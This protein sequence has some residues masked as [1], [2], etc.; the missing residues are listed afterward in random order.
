MNEMSFDIVTGA[1]SRSA[2]QPRLTQEISRARRAGGPC[3]VFLFDVD[4]FKTVNDVYGHQRGDAVLRQIADRV[5]AAIRTDDTLFRFGGDEFV[6]LLPDTGVQ[7]AV[8]LALRLTEQVRG[9]PFGDE[10]PLHLSIS[11]GVATYPQDGTDETTLLRV[12]DRRNYLAKHRGRG[13]AVADDVETSSDPRSSRLWERDTALAGTHHYL[14][15]LDAQRRGALRVT[16]QPGA[17]HTRFLQEIQRLAALRGFSV[18][19]VG[20]AVPPAPAGPTLLLADLNTTEALCATLARWERDGQ[21]PDVLG[22]AYAS[23]GIA[24]ALPSGFAELGVVD[25]PPWSPA[26]QRIWLRSVLQGEPD[27]HL[28]DWI[29]RQSGGLP[30]AAARELS[31]LRQ[32]NGLVDDGAGGWTIRP[33]LRGRPGRQVRLP[34]TVTALVGRG[35]ERTRVAELLRGSRLVTL[36]GPGGIGKTRLSLAVAAAVADEYDDGAVFVAL[37][38]T[39]TAD[40][41]VRAL[42]AALDVDEIPG[43]PLL[44]GITEHLAEASLLLVLDNLEQALDA[45]PVLGHLLGAAPGVAALATSR[46]ALAVYG[47]QVYRV[48]P[49]PLPDLHGLPHGDDGVALALTRSPAVALFDQ[50]ARAARDDFRLSTDNLA[51]VVELCRRLDGLP[52]AIE[53]AAAR[54]VALAPA[55]LLEHLG[56]HLDALGDGPRDRPERQQT[57]RG[58]IDWSVA[59]LDADAQRLFEAVGVFTGGATVPA[60]AAVTTPADDIGVEPGVQVKT[61]GQALDAL[62]AKSLLVADA[63]PDGQARYRM[64]ETIRAYAVA[65]L[66]ERDP[67]PVRDRH[68]DYF[69]ALADDAAEGMAGPGQ[70][71]WSDTI[72]REY[73]N[74]RTAMAWSL[75]RGD[76]DVAA[77]ICRGLWRYWRHG[78]ELSEGR[79]WLDRVLAGLPEPTDDEPADG[80]RADAERVAL[81]YPAAV[82]AATQDDDASATRY[83]LAS[84]RLTEASGDRQGTAQARNILGVAAMRAGR[85][86]EATEHFG[87]GLQVWRELDQP[88]G[89]AIALGNL[90]KVCLRQGRTEAAAGHINEC[91]ALERASGNSSGV[92]LGLECLGEILLAQDR[93]LDASQV[94]AEA[95]S[96]SR[97]LGDVF[98]EATALHQ[99]GQI[100]RRTGDPAA[101]RELFGA[102]LIRRHEVGDRED[103]AVSFDCL[104]DLAV[105]DRPELAVRLLAAAEQL[106]QSQRIVAPPDIDGRRQATLDGARTAIGGPAFAA[107]WRAG[108]R[109]PLDLVVAEATASALPQ[110]PGIRPVD[111]VTA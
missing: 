31:R 54:T 15:Q 45:A 59:L 47:E 80:E 19:P 14:T 30:A 62:V 89:T 42:A 39:T 17:G 67:V 27:D 83:G 9:L 1:W 40:E 36:L 92:L 51:A 105:D 100:A 87:F 78:R 70:A 98:G 44:D 65:R 11:L 81:L 50:R 53:L 24:M 6:V 74:L 3:S 85:F 82:L 10:P 7:D 91:L 49:L 77:R 43:Q 68:R 28:V 61:V 16:G 96:L 102:A 12:A 26:T 63:D 108:R 97:E 86:D 88:Q 35:D 93:L 57:L 109:A 22:V 25:L 32:R 13:S 103:L 66:A 33:D 58:A 111:A 55:A 69:A 52:L 72:T 73:A 110:A 107:A 90:A 23:T 38:D 5:S 41:V 20:G 56:R 48:P 18:L 101:A 79:R 21:L 84:L 94:A 71:A 76:A 46:E 29:N 95:L 104:A 106:R 2:L 37:A 4:Y 34:A 75:D 64:L 8:R 60:A 99:Q